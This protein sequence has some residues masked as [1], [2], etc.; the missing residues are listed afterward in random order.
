MIFISY[1]CTVLAQSDSLKID[2]LKKVLVTEKEDTNKVKS[3]YKLGWLYYPLNFEKALQYEKSALAL[4]QKIKSTNI[5][6][7]CYL[8]I[9]QILDDM[10]NRIEAMQYYYKALQIY[11]EQKN[12]Y[13]SASVLWNIGFSQ[14]ALE[15]YNEAYDAYSKGLSLLHQADSANNFIGAAC[16]IYS[17]KILVMRH[18]LAKAEE[19][20]TIGLKIS[21]NIQDVHVQANAYSTSGDI[22]LQRAQS[23]NS[24]K[25]RTLLLEKAKENYLLSLNDFTESGDIGGEGD[26]YTNL[27][28]SDILLNNLEEAQKYSDSSLAYA[29]KTNFK[30]NF[31]EAYW[32]QFQVDSAYGNFK[33]AFA[34]HKKYILYLDNIVN[35]EN[36]KK[37]LQTSLQYEFD[38][39]EAVVKA[40]QD[41]KDADAKRIKSQQYFAITAL[42]VVVLAIL[43]I[44]VIQF[45]NN[46][47][48]QKAN[49][50]LQQQ[51]E[52]VQSTLSELKSTQAQLIQAEKMASL[53]EL[54]AGIAHEIQNPLNFVN[55]FSEVN[56]E[57][58][59]ELKEEIDKGN[60]NDAKIIADDIEANE[61]KINHHG[62]R[63]DAIV[64]GMLQHSKQTSGT[65][66]PTDINALCDEYLRLSYHGLRAKDKFFNAD[67]KTDFDESISKINVV[68]QDIGRVLLNLFNNA[69]YAV[70]EKFTVNHSLP[71]DNYQPLVSVQTKKI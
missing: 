9:G 25:N 54:T 60:Y 69:F 36:V 23:G 2:S 68:P 55:N 17:A 21:T 46:K 22:F 34:N 65:K 28:F 57:M 45:K 52:E 51:K 20:N 6:G 30:D 64:K 31:K 29:A 71:T 44:A 41:K 33:D 32:V 27:A 40:E 59:A 42:G 18:A 67:F 12:R 15:N 63:A 3:L 39:K 16:Y 4:A 35:D 47:Q 24:N 26:E 5:I 66:E 13:S 19:Y 53:G 37:T 61:E 8:T 58:I 62:K 7:D 43:V 70:N 10:D 14:T 11:Q 50:L 49:A 48:K 38:K 56:K 1:A